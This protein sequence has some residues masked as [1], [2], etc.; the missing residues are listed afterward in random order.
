MSLTFLAG[1]SANVSEDDLK[2]NDWTIEPDEEDV[3][4]MIASFSDH[5]MTINVDVDSMES[6]TTDE[7]G[8]MGEEFAKELA[9]E[10][11]FKLE[12]TLDGDQITLQDT[13]NEDEENTYEVS[14]EDNNII[15][16]PIDDESDD[17]A[18]TITLQP[19]ENEE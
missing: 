18:E 10:M 4:N 8:Q 15:F 17:E 16:T 19:N 9:S 14:E 7:W 2:A 12:Y 5:V 13:D 1:C 11:D 3:P 6:T